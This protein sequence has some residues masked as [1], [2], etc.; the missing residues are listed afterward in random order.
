MAIQPEKNNL[1]RNLVDLAEALYDYRNNITSSTSSMPTKA[2]LI[3]QRFF[4][5]SSSVTGGSSSIPEALKR[6]TIKAYE[7]ALLSGT[8]VDHHWLEC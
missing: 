8:V 2:K 1:D 7:T 4:P 5:K 6:E 3:M